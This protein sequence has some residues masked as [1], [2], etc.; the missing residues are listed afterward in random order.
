MNTFYVDKIGLSEDG[1]KVILD[2]FEKVKDEP[3]IIAYESF[4]RDD[5]NFDEL[6]KNIDEYAEKHNINNFTLRLVVLVSCLDIMKENHDKA[7]LSEMFWEN[8]KDFGYKAKESF[9]VRGVYGIGNGVGRWY[10]MFYN[11]ERF[12]LGRLQFER[13]GFRLEKPYTFGDITINKGDMI[14]NMHIPSSGK[15]LKEDVLASFKEAYKRFDKIDGKVFIS[16][17]S[18][19]L[20]PDFKGNVFKEGT[21]LYEFVDMFEIIGHVDWERFLDGWR[22]FPNYNEAKSFDELPQDTSL[23]RAFVEYLKNGGKVGSGF[24]MMVLDETGQINK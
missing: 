8:I 4:I 18:W 22:V 6:L 11:A 20:Y 12:T 13:D 9:D 3:E 10:R 15:L 21:N 5:G 24:G 17:Y 23:Q 7:N 16:L 1:Q 19:F 2:L 14:Y